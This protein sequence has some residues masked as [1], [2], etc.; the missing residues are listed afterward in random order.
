MP[1]IPIKTRI[2]KEAWT[3]AV[4]VTLFSLVSTAIQGPANT[5][6]SSV[7]QAK[8]MPGADPIVTSAIR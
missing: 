2:P 6:P 5:D 3:V 8:L 1:K 4:L 7:L